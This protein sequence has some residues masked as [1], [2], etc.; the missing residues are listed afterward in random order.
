M[1]IKFKRPVQFI[2]RNGCF[3][4]IGLNLIVNSHSNAVSIA[5][6]TSKNAI[7]NCLIEIPVEEWKRVQAIKV[8]GA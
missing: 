3:T 2:G 6:I 5:P 7:G 8:K 4:A 1:E